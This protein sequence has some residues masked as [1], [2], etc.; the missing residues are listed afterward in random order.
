MKEF[1]TFTL[2]CIILVACTMFEKEKAGKSF[3]KEMPV[4]I[5]KDS[6]IAVTDSSVVYLPLTQ[7][8]GSIEIHKEASDRVHLEFDNPGYKKLYGLITTQDSIANI[9]FN[10]IIMPDSTMDGP[11]GREIKYDLTTNGTY[12]LIL[13]ESLMAG[14]PWE[15]DFHV[16]ISLSDQ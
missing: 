5:K 4:S 12:S 2:S 8:K 16:E 10:Q 15:G 11:F 14:D 7:G 3:E 1:V 13:S 9:R 6:I